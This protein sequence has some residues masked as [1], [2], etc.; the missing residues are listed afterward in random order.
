MGQLPHTLILSCSSSVWSAP[1]IKP[2]HGLSR[3]MAAYM[4]NL[5]M[6]MGVKDR[7]MDTVLEGE[8]DKVSGRGEGGE[9]EETGG[10]GG[11]GRDVGEM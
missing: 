6:V 5:N 1:F 9:E 10:G 8:R 3:D 7:V 4:L 2:Y 11:G